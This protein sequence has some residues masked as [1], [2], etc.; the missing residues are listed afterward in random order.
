MKDS[1]GDL[2]QGKTRW[3][4]F[5]LVFVP[6]LVAIGGLLWGVQAGAFPAQFTI[7]GQQFKVSAD[8]LRGDE[9]RQFPGWDR[10]AD[11]TNFPVA[12]SV[13]GDAELDSL[14]QSVDVPVIAA[15]FPNIDKIVLRIE[16]GQDEPAEASNL[17]IGLT[18][19]SGDATFTNI[20][21]GSDA[22]VISDTPILT[23]QFGQRADSVVIEDL[24]QTAYSTTAGT[25]RLTGLHLE[26][27][28]DSEMANGGEC[29]ATI[30]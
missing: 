29:F 22:G 2:V 12:R 9:F 20:Q 10:D 6:G 8:E 27:L 17:V 1:H 18:E 26:V 19:L 14:C 3:R 25:F 23:G 4:R 21:I 16:A 7:S 28:L 13:I 11:G 24:Q 30:E 15:L 5:A